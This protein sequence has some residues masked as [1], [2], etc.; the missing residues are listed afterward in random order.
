MKI[1]TQIQSVFDELIYEDF[2]HTRFPINNDA[3]YELNREFFK[4]KYKINSVEFPINDRLFDFAIIGK[5]TT[6]KN[7]L[8]LLAALRMISKPLYDTEIFPE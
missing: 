7:R 5:T 4:W 2:K 3:I 6:T 8:P 1:T